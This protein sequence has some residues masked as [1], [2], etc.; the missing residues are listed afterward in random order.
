[1]ADKSAKLS[2]NDRTIE[3]PV[4][5]PSEG[6]DVIDVGTLVREGYFTYDPG[7]MSTA[8]CESTI[9]YIDGDEGTLLHRGYP[10]EQLAEQS[11]YLE[12]TYLLL[13]GK[14][15]SVEEFE[16]Y[17]AQIRK[18]TV[19]DE[20]LEAI[21]SH[22]P[23][24]AHP[25]GVMC[26]LLGAM[27]AI[28]HTE[29]DITDEANRMRVAIRL[30]AQIPICAAL[31]YRHLVGKP[32]VSAKPELD[33]A[34]HFLHLM[35]SDSD[36]DTVNPILAQAMD[37]VFLL[38]AD[39]EQN[40][41]TSTVR[42]AGSTD[43][44][45]Y[46]CIAA[47][48]A[49]L[50]GPAHGGANEAV[51]EMLNEMGSTDN[52]DTYVNKAK[53]SSDPFR[54]MGFGHRVYKNYDPR[55]RV[56]QQT[57]N[58]VLNELGIENDE[59]LQMARALEKVALEDPYFIERRL[60]PNVDFYSGIILKA[61]GIP[62]ELFTVIFVTGRTSGWIAQWME[63]VSTPYKINRPRQMYTGDCLRNYVPIAER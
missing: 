57:C 8:S 42:M 56:M 47:G 25:M 33:Y 13:Y 17:Q 3:L 6:P 14:L 31:A 61:M 20:R 50:W 51:L 28:Y 45:P 2:V 34:E 60:Y 29:V 18:E 32:M 7:Y 27:A 9:T 41:S 11:N 55:A 23:N 26:S 12:L 22:L 36:D 37:R 24:N 15:P 38:H 48:I 63:M 59:V 40:A 10:I 54:I 1:M 4:M 30:I 39:H 19:V 52:V 43:S 49:A 16:T 53:D 46:S 44:N 62:V 21:C 58:E 35:F 5:S